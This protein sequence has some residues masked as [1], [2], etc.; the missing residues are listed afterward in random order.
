PS[1]RRVL[2]SIANA[3]KEKNSDVTEQAKMV[4]SAIAQSES[5]AGRSGRISYSIIDTIQTSALRMFDPQH[6]GFGQAPKFPHPSALDLLIERYARTT[7]AHGGPDPLVRPAEQSSAASAPG[8]A[9][10]D[11]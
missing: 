10:E 8:N 11:N 3:Y 7:K 1:F 6:G 4:E 9:A 2:L 5:F